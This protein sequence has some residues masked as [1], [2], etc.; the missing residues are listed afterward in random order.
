MHALTR[1]HAALADENRIRLLAAC[2]DGQRCVCQLVELLT[3]ANATVSKHLSILHDAGLLDRS[4][5]GRWVH[6]RL[7]DEPTPP[8]AN[9]IEHLRCHLAHDPIIQADRKHMETI[10]SFDPIALCRAQRNGCCLTDPDN[11]DHKECCR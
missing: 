7:P 2:F 8:A 3:L 6:Y 5:R 4:K 11:T 1:I 10:L 9:A